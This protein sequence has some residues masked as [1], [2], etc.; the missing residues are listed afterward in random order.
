MVE[1]NSSLLIQLVNFLVMIF[2]LNA[3]LYK[4]ILGSWIGGR[5]TFRIWMKK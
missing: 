3:I 4:P 5:S 1:L 2:L